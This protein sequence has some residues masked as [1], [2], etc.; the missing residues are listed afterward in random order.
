MKL[1]SD[2]K[3]RSTVIKANIFILLSCLAVGI[4]EYLYCIPLYLNYNSTPTD[5]LSLFL[6]STGFFSILH[7][8]LAV[9]I[10]LII[11]ISGYINNKKRYY[12]AILSFIFTLLNII[13]L[14]IVSSYFL[15]TFTDSNIYHILLTLG[16]SACISTIISMLIVNSYNDFIN[17]AKKYTLFV[18]IF[19]VILLGAVFS[20]S[21]KIL[22]NNQYLLTYYLLL[23]LIFYFLIFFNYYVAFKEEPL[24]NIKYKYLLI[25]SII[26]IIF[27]VI[28]FPAN[29]K[30]ESLVKKHIPFEK[31]IISHISQILDLDRDGF[32]PE[33]IVS[34]GDKN[35]FNDKLSPCTKD[36][37]GNF[38]D[39]NGING[40]L[41]THYLDRRYVPKKKIPSTI[42][43]IMIITIDNIDIDKELE[44]NEGFLTELINK[45]VYFPQA[46]SISKNKVVALNGLFNSNL[47][48]IETLNR[49]K[50]ILP[51]SGSIFSLYNSKKYTTHAFLDIPYSVINNIFHL[52]LHS[53]TIFANN[54]KLAHPIST[55]NI[56]GILKLFNNNKQLSWIYFDNKIPVSSSK[57]VES[58]FKVLKTYN[59]LDKSLFIFVFLPESFNDNNNYYTSPMLFFYDGIKPI[60][61]NTRISHLDLLPTLNS[62]SG[63]SN[64][65]KGYTGIDLSDVIA[66]NKPLEK[67]TLMSINSDG[68]AITIIYD[69]Y[70]LI[71]SI[72]GSFYEIYYLKK[73]PDQKNN[74]INNNKP[75][76]KELFYWL[77][78]F[79]A[80]GSSN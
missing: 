2:Q 50:Q 17:T 16:L 35:N 13:P 71:Y 32:G 21:D 34:G 23:S 25:P 69:N 66:S 39:E 62:L 12:F 42:T 68:T 8:F 14:Y 29:L 4:T 46:I 27:T 65:D 5:L 26:G 11:I 43:N 40:D 58:I 41:S 10:D 18:F 55:Q 47:K 52:N 60:K 22:D 75:V 1:F 36:K 30:L 31:N 74:L 77:D 6:Y 45:G 24:F 38:I 73:D 79:L 56:A 15:K 19:F 80:N 7:I 67:R 70:K 61:I 53:K 72:K 20:I 44:K 51:N 9:A 28:Y 78:F 48:N 57:R 64:K 37:P 3:I 59:V 54:N 33:Y 49:V 76:F 63:I